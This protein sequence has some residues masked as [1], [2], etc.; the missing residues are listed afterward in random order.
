MTAG[1]VTRVHGDDVDGESLAPDPGQKRLL[2]GNQMAVH[3][4]GGAGLQDDVASRAKGRLEVDG[5]P[6]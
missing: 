4:P 6:G 1:H 2:Q 5:P 3:Q